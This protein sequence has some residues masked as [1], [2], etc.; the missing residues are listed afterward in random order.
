MFDEFL[1]DHVATFLLSLHLRANE[2]QTIRSPQVDVSDWILVE[3]FK[4][5]S[6]PSTMG[7][8]TTLTS[9]A[10]DPTAD[11]QLPQ[12]PEGLDIQTVYADFIGYLYKHTKL[13]FCEHVIE[14]VCPFFLALFSLLTLALSRSGLNIW[15]RLAGTA[16]FVFGHPDG[17][18]DQQQQVLRLALHQAA[19]FS[20][21]DPEE[22]LKFVRESEAS[23]HYVLHNQ[24][25]TNWLEVSVRPLLVFIYVHMMTFDL[26]PGTAFTVLDGGGSTIDTALF[27]CETATPRLT[28][29]LPKTSDCIQAG[30]VFMT[31]AGVVMF[32]NQLEG[33]DFDTE[34]NLEK[35]EIEFES[36][37]KRQFTGVEQR[38]IFVRFRTAA[39]NGPKAG[40]RQGR[41]VLDKCT[42]LLCTRLRWMTHLGDF[43]TKFEAQCFKPFSDEVVA[44][45]L[46]Q[47]QFGDRKSKVLIL[48]G[49]LAESPYIKRKLREALAAEGI[50]VITGDETSKKAV[51]EGAILW[52]LKELVVSRAVRSTFRIRSS[53]VLS[54]KESYSD[55]NV[56]ETTS[57]YNRDN[58]EYLA[59]GHCTLPDRTRAVRGSFA[60][61]IES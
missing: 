4:S 51:A 60:T 54:R 10:S 27:V 19:I 45:A 28:L 14:W 26:Q 29:C 43:R 44:S 34:K 24:N 38:D 7:V 32:K 5:L 20:Q 17:W 12:L 2:N 3:H 52:F 39:D 59:R 18:N 21:N 11:F 40:I 47:S 30:G 46:R 9:S 25:V 22:R 57:S 58:P 6:H 31:K 42:V 53:L 16:T 50:K 61:I 56:A 48:V 37:T 35:L 33:T 1:Q 55:M 23:V 15:D 8:A 36:V 49:G 13:Y 41:L